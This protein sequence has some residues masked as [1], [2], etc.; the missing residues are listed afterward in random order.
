MGCLLDESF[1]YDDEPLAIE[2]LVLSTNVAMTTRTKQIGPPAPDTPFTAALRF[3]HDPTLAPPL[4]PM[5]QR[6]PPPPLATTPDV[7]VD[8][9]FTA[10]RKIPSTKPRSPSPLK[11][12]T[13]DVDDGDVAVHDEA[14]RSDFQS[15]FAM[16]VPGTAKRLTRR[17]SVEGEDEAYPDTSPSSAG[18]RRA[19]GSGRKWSVMSKVLEE[20]RRAS[21]A[22]DGLGSVPE[23][24][25]QSFAFSNLSTEYSQILE[26][27]GSFILEGADFTLS[28]FSLPKVIEEGDETEEGED[29]MR[30]LLRGLGD[31]LIGGRP[32]PRLGVLPTL[33]LPPSSSSLQL[34]PTEDHERS[35]LASSTASYREYRDSPSKERAVQFRPREDEQRTPV[36]VR[37]DFLNDG[38]GTSGSGTSGSGTSGSG[39]GSATETESSGDVRHLLRNWRGDEAATTEI[40]EQDPPTGVL[41]HEPTLTFEMGL[42]SPIRPTQP[43]SR[44]RAA[45]AP[46]P[47]STAASSSSSSSSAA[48]PAVLSTA[49]LFG[50]LK[51]SVRSVATGSPRRPLV[52]ASQSSVDLISLDRELPPKPALSRSE[53][54]TERLRAKIE[55]LKNVKRGN[56]VPSALPASAPRARTRTTPS[57]SVATPAPRSLLRPRPSLA[58]P[59]P[60]IPHPPPPTRPTHHRLA[61]I[62]DLESDSDTSVKSSKEN[63]PPAPSTL[64]VS[65]RKET[66]RER[67]ERA[68]EERARRISVTVQ[69]ALD[70]LDLVEL[71]NGQQSSSSVDLVLLFLIVLDRQLRPFRLELQAPTQ[72]HHQSSKSVPRPA[73]F[74][75]PHH[76]CDDDDL[77]AVG[78]SR[79]T[80]VPPSRAQSTHF[81][82]PALRLACESAR[83]A[84]HG[85]AGNDDG[86]RTEGEDARADAPGFSVNIPIRS[87]SSLTSS[88]AVGSAGP[89]FKSVARKSATP[90]TA[91]TRR[92]SSL[93]RTAS[94]SSSLKSGHDMVR[95]PEDFVPTSSRLKIYHV[96]IETLEIEAC[97]EWIPPPYYD[98]SVEAGI[99]NILLKPDVSLPPLPVGP[100][101]TPLCLPLTDDQSPGRLLRKGE[102]SI[103]D[104][105]T[106]VKVRWRREEGA[107][108]ELLDLASRATETLPPAAKM[109]G[110]ER[111][112]A[113]ILI[114]NLGAHRSIYHLATR[115]PYT[116]GDTYEHSDEE[117]SLTTNS[118]TRRQDAVAHY[119]LR[120]EVARH[121]RSLLKLDLLTTTQWIEVMNGLDQAIEKYR[122]NANPE[123]WDGASVG[124]A[125]DGCFKS[126]AR[127]EPVIATRWDTDPAAAGWQTE[128][129]TSYVTATDQIPTAITEYTTFGESPNVDGGTTTITEW[130]STLTVEGP[131]YLTITFY[132]T[133]TTY[134]TSTVKMPTT[135]KTKTKTHAA[136]STATVCLPGDASKKEHTGLTPTHDQS[137]TLYV[138]AIY[139]VGIGIGWNLVGIRDLIFPF[140]M[141]TVAIHEVG[142]ILVYICFGAHVSEVCLDP[143][144]GGKVVMKEIEP[145]IRYAIPA[146]GLPAGYLFN[147]I[148]GGLLTYCGFDTLA[149]KIASFVGLWFVDHAWGLR[150]YILFVGVMN[151]FYVYV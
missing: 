51:N 29:D 150:F 63:A 68:K 117:T 71:L 76:G 19:S 108:V 112:K 55:A 48:A 95:D 140:K 7:L 90:T 27:R 42:Q 149:S 1:E 26:E 56:P 28:S 47:V 92:P 20:K 61:S 115:V 141:L 9:A 102:R 111:K 82:R 23:D 69:A 40:N 64:S 33:S 21:P 126:L 97:E 60:F 121:L 73:R 80:R 66:T 85:H 134:H 75:P 110:K 25:E 94:T 46:T 41:R 133:S 107:P 78:Q 145:G 104:N 101:L 114:P 116:P 128:T 98:V 35:L 38:S 89:A 93:N 31:S 103:T 106:V 43:P 2:P 105:G 87:R 13:F 124:T 62:P 34:P 143:N 119:G 131:S 57:P 18:S 148:V 84:P 72:F 120:R 138:I 54:G 135:T 130:A 11:H 151:S 74:P 10:Y 118:I 83:Q 39:G 4:P 132:P 59:S 32:P 65:P 100:T 24:A 67:L 147:I 52:P 113:Q 36:R 139:L 50:E 14:D 22:R 5:S 123:G 129:F 144:Q 99:T 3:S 49:L 30:H 53:S 142:H 77:G 146:A 96:R 6:T 81:H 37:M 70:V 125:S 45:P 12:V 137:I 91:A 8:L 136:A 109:V 44:A 17:R 122:N 86:R 15:P 127:D 88:S 16:E 79:P 58:S